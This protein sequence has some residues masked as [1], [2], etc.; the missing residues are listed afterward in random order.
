MVDEEEEVV[1]GVAVDMATAI[2][3]AREWRCPTRFDKDGI[4]EDSKLVS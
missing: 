1:M 4:G 2:E 3:E